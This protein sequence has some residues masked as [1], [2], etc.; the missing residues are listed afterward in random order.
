MFSQACVIPSV[1]SVPPGRVSVQRRSARGVGVVCL[2]R[3][4]Y[5]QGGLTGRLGVCMTGVSVQRGGVPA[6][7]SLVGY[8]PT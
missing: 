4:V 6:R 8:N 1:P 2:P 7:G 3:G 5:V